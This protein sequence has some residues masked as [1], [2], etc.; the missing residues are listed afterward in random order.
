[1]IRM[2]TRN[3]VVVPTA[4]TT[5]IPALRS[6]PLE[7]PTPTPPAPTAPALPEIAGV[8]RVDTVPGRSWSGRVFALALLV[9]TLAGLTWLSAQIYY[10][11]T[12]GW[13]APAHLS[14]DNDTVAQLRLQHQRQLADLTR[15]DAEVTRI[16]GELL[17]IDAA[18][19]KLSELRGGSQATLTW[20]AEQSRIEGNGLS[21]ATTFLERQLALVAQ[22]HARQRDLIARSR[23]DLA[24]GL[25]DRSALDREEQAGDQLALETTELQRQIAESRVRRAHNRVTLKAL[26]A[27]T[28]LGTAPTVG[29]MPEVA[30]GDEHDVRI[31]V[32]IQR[33]NAEARGH[34]AQRAAALSTATK[35]KELLTELEARPLY[36]AMLVDTEI[37]FVPYD[38]IASATPGARI[39]D[40]V[41]GVFSCHD[42]G[43][44]TELMRGEVVM[45]DPWGEMARGQYA[46][47]QLDDK[48]A[49][50][51]RVLRVRN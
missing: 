42:V 29:T 38:Q 20:Q 16:D 5:A 48:S 18:I 30:A 12:D 25:I 15:V 2:I 31:E 3:L 1:M 19:V 17:A 34:R 51:E 21:A 32:E 7:T 13:I 22:L 14:I 23:D 28:G 36:R 46:I 27:S 26:R 35:Q 8:P 33:L 40:C 50:R 43:R 44:V 49:I 4:V 41:W 9:G 45:Q 24:A 10:V 6:V 39:V 37:A 11:I 47:L